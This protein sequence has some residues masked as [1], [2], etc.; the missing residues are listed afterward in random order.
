MKILIVIYSLSQTLW[1]LQKV[2]LHVCMYIF[3]YVHTYVY[4]Q[5]AFLYPLCLLTLLLYNFCEIFLI[6]N[7]DNKQ[8]Q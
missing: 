7:T 2:L 4:T 5:K 6:Y 8:A 3:M 1:S